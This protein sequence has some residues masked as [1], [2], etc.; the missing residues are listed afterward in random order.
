MCKSRPAFP[1]MYEGV[2]AHEWQHLLENYQDPGEVPWL[3]EGLS[4]IAETLVGY[5]ET[6]RTVHQTNAQRD[7]LCFNGFGTIKGPSNPN[8][9]ACGGPQNSLTTWGDEGQ[10]SEIL[11]DYGNARSFM[12]FLLDRYGTEFIGALHT[13]SEHYG[14]GSVQAALD[15]T[16]G[17]VKVADVLHDFQI[18]T[19]ID[20]YLDDPRTKLSGIAKERVTTKSLHSTV[21][22]RNPSAFAVPGAAPNGADYVLLKQ[23]GKALAGSALRSVTFSGDR[24]IA[25]DPESN[26]G[27]IVIPVPDGLPILGTE[28]TGATVDNWHVS[29][30]GIDA[31]GRKILVSSRDKAFSA[32]WSAE[33]LKAFA[34]YPVVVAVIS[35]D[36]TDELNLAAEQYARYALKV[37][38][39]LQIGG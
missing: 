25:G 23:G 1:H 11:A 37:N 28:N 21:N 39:T 10:G 29:L 5:A 24:A 36:N 26:A 35:H 7:L 6:T 20:R 27:D 16:A 33:A 34:A 8:P 31:A 13:D 3:N 17:G 15:R 32:S 9:V 2:F 19:L 38:G 12:L 30:V 4:M 14:L 18:S 22:L